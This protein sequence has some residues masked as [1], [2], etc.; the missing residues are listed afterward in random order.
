MSENR[1]PS[2]QN[3]FKVHD[4]VIFGSLVQPPKVSYPNPGIFSAIILLIIKGLSI[5][6]GQLGVFIGDCGNNIVLQG[7][8]FEKKGF[9]IFDIPH[10]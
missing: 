9:A 2:C 3:F 6:E 1:G 7:R 10:P 5:P 8:I 4:F